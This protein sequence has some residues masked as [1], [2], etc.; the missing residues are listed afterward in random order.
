M[1][2]PAAQFDRLTPADVQGSGQIVPVDPQRHGKR[3]IY[4]A[5]SSPPADHL[6]PIPD[7]FDLPGVE[8]FSV[9]Y[10]NG[11]TYTAQDLAAMVAA[12]QP[13]L[14]ELHP[15]ITINHR[16]PADDDEDAGFALGHVA[17][18]YTNAAPV[19]DQ[20][21]RLLQPGEL[22]LA[23]L[24]NLP[25]ELA[26]AVLRR[27]VQR[28]SIELLIDYEDLAGRT[29]PRVL[30]AVSFE[31]AELEA[32]RNLRDLD[33][34]YRPHAA[35]GLKRGQAAARRFVSSM[36]LNTT[37]VQ[38][39]ATDQPTG[40]PAPKSAEDRLGAIEGQLAQ[41]VPMLAGLEKLV[42]LAPALAKLVEQQVASPVTPPA[43]GA[44]P[45]D[46]T[47]Q[48]VNNAAKTAGSP[49]ECKT[50][51]AEEKKTEMAG[52]IK[53]PDCGAMCA[54]GSKFCPNCGKQLGQAMA[55]QQ[56][57]RQEQ[58]SVMPGDEQARQFADL[59]KEIEADVKRQF[60]AQRVQDEARV[61]AAEEKAAAAQDAVKFMQQEK[62]DSAR[63]AE[64][65]SYVDSI[66]SPQRC[67]IPPRREVREQLEYLLL[68][69]PNGN[70]RKFAQGGK[71]LDY[72]ATLKAFVESYPNGARLFGQQ[73]STKVE[74]EERQF[75]NRSDIAAEA[76]RLIAKQP[77]L[78]MFDAL[79]Q[80]RADIGADR[81]QAA[82]A[83]VQD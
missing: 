77:G 65:R 2:A 66:S 36:S 9:G 71:E 46:T 74:P 40:A 53:C 42:T 49:E 51:M 68:N 32:V 33:R 12:F 63:A 34:L 44:R 3:S 21:G 27:N 14:S 38:A 10:W 7:T 50:P 57:M 24:V 15:W 39:M 16:Q 47:V 28:P 5:L 54:A 78:A 41:I 55:A 59:R 58:T 30:Q 18:L 62:K 56:N 13:L 22:L 43:D 29:W 11:E 80:V 72:Q 60:A 25:R 19:V 76:E 45:A 81:F 79:Q 8:V 23:D 31:G 82:M 48:T 37:G 1:S 70:T 6:D 26:L 4:S 35:K 20:Q 69:A 64:V 73:T 52:E 17:R 67:H 75:R 61:K 83:D